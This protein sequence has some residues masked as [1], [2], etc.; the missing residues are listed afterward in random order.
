VFDVT[1]GLQPTYFQRASSHLRA[2]RF[3]IAEM[4][5]GADVRCVAGLGTNDSSKTAGRDAIS[6][7][8]E[9]SDVGSAPT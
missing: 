6:A 3:A 5:N 1:L 2:L 7:G 4:P 9:R 8:N